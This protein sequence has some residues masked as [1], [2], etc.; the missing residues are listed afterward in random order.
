MFLKFVSNR[1]VL[2][3]V[4]RFVFEVLLCYLYVQVLL[5]VREVL[6]PSFLRGLVLGYSSDPTAE[7]AYFRPGTLTWPTP[8]LYCTFSRGSLLIGA[9]SADSEHQSNFVRIRVRTLG[10]F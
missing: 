2:R 1:F 3:F 8:T 7:E 6:V 9:C 5:R 4:L 10:L